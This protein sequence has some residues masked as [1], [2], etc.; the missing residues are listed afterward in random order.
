MS[1]IDR[2]RRSLARWAAR[3]PACRLLVLHGSEAGGHTWPE[4]DVDLAI[5]CDPMPS[6]EERLRIIGA[7]QDRCGGRRA[8]VTFL[9]PGTDPVLRFEV[10]KRG[11][12]LYEAEPGLFVE[13]RVRAVMLHQDAIPFR[14]ALVERMRAGS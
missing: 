11:V 10:F 12:P 5:A 7:L 9:R 4:S 3:E 14:R 1:E 6:P 13:E 8:D 2:A